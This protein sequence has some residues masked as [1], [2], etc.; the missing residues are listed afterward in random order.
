MLRMMKEGGFKE[1]FAAFDDILAKNKKLVT[2]SVFVG[3]TTWLMLSSFYH[4][5]ERDNPKMIWTYPGCYSPFEE[6]DNLDGRPPCPH[7][8]GSIL[9]SSYFTLLNLF[10]EF[11]LVD[12]HSTAGRYLG[13]FTAV[14]AVAVFAIPTG[15]FGAGFEDMIRLRKQKALEDSEAA[16]MEDVF[17]DEGKV[18]WGDDTPESATSRP[19]ATTGED[20]D[21]P[22]YSFLD[23]R[24]M[25]GRVYSRVL[26]AV[27]MLDVVAFFLSTLD[28]LEEGK[29]HAVA[30]ALGVIELASVFLF[31][32]DYIA[33]ALSA[34]ASRSGG[35]MR[36]LLSFYGL[37]DLLSVLPFF[38]GLPTFGG[39]ASI[40]PKLL[41]TLVRSL[42]LIR[43]LKL[44][45]YVRA[46][47]V[48]DDVVRGNLDILAVSGFFALVAW[49][50]ASSLLFFT[51]SQG[52]DPE[53]TPYYESVPMAMWVTLLNLSGE[54]PLCDYTAW[55]KVITG[56]LGIFGVAVFAVPVGLLGAGFEEWVETIQ[57]KEA[58]KESEEF[59]RR[60]DSGAYTRKD[61]VED[62]DIDYEEGDE[63]M[64]EEVGSARAF[65]KRLYVFMEARTVWGRRFE[66]FIMLVIIITVTQTIL[67]TMPSV[68]ADETSCPT[69]FE[70]VEFVAVI[71]FTVEYALR[72][73]AAPEAY[74]ELSPCVARLRYS[75]SFYAV[76]DF[77]AIFPYYLAQTSSWV[78]EYDN[79]LRLLRILRILK[80]D[81]YA[82]CVSLIDDVFW[83]KAKGLL[84]AGF[85]SVVMLAWFG[86][87][88]FLV[89]KDDNKVVID[90]Y[91][92][93]D[94][95]SSVVNSLQYDLI[96]LTGD[97][98]LIDF[99]ILGRF[100]NF[101]QQIVVAVGVVAVPSG[102]IANGFSQVL[103]ERRNEK[104]AKRRAAAVQL[105]RQV[106]GHLARRQFLMTVEDAQQQE[107]ERKHQKRILEK[108]QEAHLPAIERARR[109]VYRFSTGVTQA[110]KIFDAFVAV[111]I[112]LN[113]IAVIAE[114][115]SRLGGRS[116]SATGSLDDGGSIQA[117]FD[118][119]EAFSVLVF[120]AE[121]A[122]RFFIAP[123]SSE[124]NRSRWNYMTSFFGI[125][126]LA[127]IVPWYVQMILSLSGVYFDASVFRV[128]RMF[129][130]LQLE[131]FVSAFTLLDDVWSSCQD[132]LAATG[133]LA[134][135]VWVGSACLFYLFE[136]NN[137]CTGDAFKS[138][139]DAMY[140]VAVFLAGEWGKMD[141]TWPGKILCCV[142]CVMGIALFAIPVGTVFEAF[143]DVLEE[144]NTSEEEK[145][146]KTSSD[147]KEEP[148]DEFA[149]FT[150]K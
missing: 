97:Y 83:L 16:G 126:D 66:A 134:L 41:P 114:S 102:L 139:P 108:D 67:M 13:V 19:N 53:M 103:E 57:S 14:V 86:T 141:F 99:T 144:V 129:R 64:G 55:G 109:K 54:A 31:T 6:E 30:F 113:V 107:E 60:Q 45:R 88:M 130:I 42:R 4:I 71:I 20:D 17:E 111:L 3:V 27:V 68:C 93:A 143:Q 28:Y 96:L 94:R 76:I 127:S 136:K 120:T 21:Q 75:M 91:T 146:P 43:M 148:E 90:C 8:F 92:E 128:V 44:E 145:S 65:R 95:F 112:L 110:G 82:P 5:A 34:A 52:P 137:E 46:F 104:H 140:Y 10:G 9:S 62:E 40:S 25:T 58:M 116:N 47:T 36:Y 32:L 37:V 38:L 117:F 123:I 132:T 80:L 106:R 87:I 56:V 100:V 84:V 77:L 105:Q 11:P 23:T 150:F 119:F 149:G 135:V 35:L 98:P 22:L 81:K 118:G 133:L 131:H 51:E 101:V 74:P 1:A 147:A 85:A 63:E 15:I 12:E 122:M 70:I 29:M 48:F 26:V 79:Y 142:L 50:F 18:A 121:I 2:A 39:I 7:R 115:D 124:Y 89:E 49:V 59:S 125:I 73:Y 33:R 69:A 24:T 72:I 138:I 78:D 61:D